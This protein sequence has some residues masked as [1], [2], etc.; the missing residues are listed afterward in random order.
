MLHSPWEMRGALR[1]RITDVFVY[2]PQGRVADPNVEIRATS[3]VAE[4]NPAAVLS[5]RETIDSVA[6]MEGSAESER[7]Q[8]M[9]AL[10]RARLGEVPEGRHPRDQSPARGEPRGRRAA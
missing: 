8:R 2:S 4:E 10:L 3:P 9:L 1:E 5:M 6:A 7:T